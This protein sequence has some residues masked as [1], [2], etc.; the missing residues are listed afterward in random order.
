[1][2]VIA[3]DGHTLAADKLACNGWT[4]G[5]VTKIWRHGRELLGVCGD[6]PIGLEL[7]D[8]YAAGAV[9]PDFPAANR[10]QDKGASLI[11]VK[12]NGEVWKYESGPIPFRVEGK[13]CAFGS[14]DEA[15]LVAM[16]CGR[17]AA[18]AVGLASMVN[19]TCGNGID[20]L[21]IEA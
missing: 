21:T 1:M 13:F 16:H 15:A 6:L 20:A 3:W 12:P 11:V 10:D 14:G 2:T 5:T 19:T 9:R 8:W 18:E 7:R 17:T 4:R